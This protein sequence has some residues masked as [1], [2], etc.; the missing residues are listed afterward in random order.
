MFRNIGFFNDQDISKLGLF[1]NSFIDQETTGV[2][3]L[4]GEETPFNYQLAQSVFKN[5][6]IPICGGIFPGIIYDSKPLKEGILAIGLNSELNIISYNKLA[7]I[8]KQRLTDSI[9]HYPTCLVLIDGLA[10]NISSFLETLFSSSVR[11]IKYIG[12]GAGSL[13]LEQKPV[14]FTKEDFW[15]RGCILIYINSVIGLGVDHGWQPMHGPIVAN[16]ARH[17]FL[18]EINWMPAFSYYSQVLESLTGTNINSSNFFEIAKRYPFGMNKSDGT[19]VVRDP[20]AIHG[21]EA[22][23][24]VGEV[25]SNSIL[26]ILQGENKSLIKAAGKATQEA[27]NDYPIDQT[28]KE[29]ACMLVVSCI[30]RVLFLDEEINSE[31][32]AIQDN[33][34]YALPLAGFFTLGEVASVCDRYLEFFNKSIVI[35]VG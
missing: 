22:L 12:G 3:L 24:L 5:F 35:G 28:N 14:L 27:Y 13:T 6:N 31:I 11:N 9:N 29:P 4:V 33:N 18:Y 23:K 21:K 32:R 1:L 7:D 20:I 8:Q 30:S 19:I 2:L 34:K 15:C 16:D 17:H 10:T 26:S 25:P